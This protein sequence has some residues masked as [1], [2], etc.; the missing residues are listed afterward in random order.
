MKKKPSKKPKELTR[1]T[2][3]KIFYAALQE[4]F[5]YRREKTIT[6]ADGTVTILPGFPKRVKLKDKLKEDLGLD[7]LDL[8]E[9]GMDVEEKFAEFS[10]VDEIYFDAEDLKS[11]VTV[12]NAI[13]FFVKAVNERS[14]LTQEEILEKVK[15]KYNFR[16][17]G[18]KED[19]KDEIQ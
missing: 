12:G 13:D 3:K 7:S 15:E 6:N 10:G 5:S 11:L 1:A 2:A 17:M 9:L 18:L 16:D 4:A 14:S 19:D 8:T